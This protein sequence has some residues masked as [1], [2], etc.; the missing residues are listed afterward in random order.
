MLM[1]AKQEELTEPVII[2]ERLR[3]HPDRNNIAI[4]GFSAGG[5]LAA[6]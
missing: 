2:L 4:M 5:H 1:E 6:D 3:Y